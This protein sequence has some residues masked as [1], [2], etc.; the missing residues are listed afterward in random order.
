VLFD[1][2]TT[3]GRMLGEYKLLTT[4]PKRDLA[5]LNASDTFEQLKL[6]PQEQLILESL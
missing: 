3:H 2:L 6:Y 4:Y 5:S 1:Y